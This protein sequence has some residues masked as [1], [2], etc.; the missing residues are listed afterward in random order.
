ML[1][2]S[3]GLMAQTEAEIERARLVGLPTSGLCPEEGA[4]WLNSSEVS[5]DDIPS[6]V[7][8]LLLF[9]GLATPAA[10][11]T[12]CIMASDALHPLLIF[13]WLLLILGLQSPLAVCPLAQFHMPSG[14]TLVAPPQEGRWSVSL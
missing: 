2:G 11:H 10:A 6:E 4:G 8:S 5:N 9:S 3:L 14:H 12:T 7:D 1:L 13:E